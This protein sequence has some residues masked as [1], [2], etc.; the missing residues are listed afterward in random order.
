MNKRLIKKYNE[1]E[2]IELQIQ[3]LQEKLQGVNEEAVEI[4]KSELHKIFKSAKITFEEYTQIITGI[5]T[6]DEV[7]DASLEREKK[8]LKK[9]LK[10][11]EV[12]NEE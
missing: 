6:K 7:R 4:E 1:S 11:G 3:A 12:Y 5:L 9:N 8:H 10:K 2:K